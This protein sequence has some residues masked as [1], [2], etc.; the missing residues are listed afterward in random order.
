MSAAQPVV[1]VF[2]ASSTQVAQSYFDAAENLAKELINS[3]YAIK[4]GG[5]AV[6][7]MGAVANQALAMQGRVIG[8]IPQ[9]MVDV[10]WQHPDVEEMHVVETMHQRKQ[11][12]IDNVDAVVALPGSS[13]TLEELMEVISMKKLGLFTKP[14]VI[15]NTNGFYD[16]L[17]DLFKRMADERFL[18]ETHLDTFTVINHP[19]EIVDAIRQSPQW[20][21]MQ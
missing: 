4:Y 20:R 7:L 2:C 5:G 6:G 10:E 8:I 1:C 17:I 9:F 21:V 12:L 16:S 15:V 11:Q 18:H 19:H 14:V 3:G 13:G